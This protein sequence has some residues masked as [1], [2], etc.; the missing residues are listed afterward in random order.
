MFSSF[1]YIS[2]RGSGMEVVVLGLVDNFSLGNFQLVFGL[3]VLGLR[4]LVGNGELRL[5]L[6]I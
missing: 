4:F 6:A 3:E 5:M 2:F 1:W